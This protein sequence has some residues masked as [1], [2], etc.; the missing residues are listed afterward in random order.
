[1]SKNNRRKLKIGQKVRFPK[2]N[3][4]IEKDRPAVVIEEQPTYYIA[5][6]KSGYLECIPAY[7]PTE[8]RI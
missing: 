4:V 7:G 8:V 3:G 5:R 1:M 6:T 2:Y